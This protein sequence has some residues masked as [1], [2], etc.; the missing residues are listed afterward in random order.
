MSE[1]KCGIILLHGWAI[2][3]PT[4]LLTKSFVTS[5]MFGL[6]LQNCI[7]KEPKAPK[8]PLSVV[9]LSSKAQALGLNLT[10]S[11]FDFNDLPS[12]CVNSEDA[13]ESKEGLQEA[14]GWV[15]KEIKDLIDCGVPSSN[16]IVL[17][18][19]QGGALTLY[20]AVHTKY[21]LG[22]F[23][24]FATWLPLL[25]AEPIT[26]V[27]TPIRVSSVKIYS[28]QHHQISM[29]QSNHDYI[30][31]VIETFIQLIKILIMPNILVNKNHV[32]Y[33]IKCHHQ[34]KDPSA[35]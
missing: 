14:L 28:P 6:G 21:K 18:Y 13:A 29:I 12:V 31:I 24:P 20:T 2:S 7:I 10:R 19:S 15:E 4:G 23:I 35:N 33:K 11:W 17:G 30:I 22:G 1:K 3:F 9:P 16:I 25:R 5:S 27:R 32:G 26:A 34:I 8:Q